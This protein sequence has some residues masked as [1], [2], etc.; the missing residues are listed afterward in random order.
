M[1]NGDERYDV[2]DCDHWINSL[3]LG[4]GDE[5]AIVARLGQ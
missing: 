4:S 2:Q 3:K 1:P 5:D